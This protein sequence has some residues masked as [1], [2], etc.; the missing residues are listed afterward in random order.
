MLTVS[1]RAELASNVA[2]IQHITIEASEPNAAGGFYAEALRLDARVLVNASEAPTTGFRGFLLGLVVAQSATV[3]DLISRAARAGAA[4]LKP[5]KRSLWGYGGVVQAPDG[6]IL[7]VASSSKNNAGPPS[8]QV[9]EIVLQLGV[10][11][12]AASRRFYADRGFFAA[13]GYGRKYV[14]FDTGAVS[15][16]LN[17]RS[18]LA[19]VAGLSAEGTGSHRILIGG[20]IAPVTDPD[21]FVWTAT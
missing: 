4:V 3:D 9:D 16:T 18:A 1:A 13:R 8:S 19:N 17:R 6:T 12:V 2:S 11:D 15:L 7:T 14:E 5:A 20:D 10:A 21:G